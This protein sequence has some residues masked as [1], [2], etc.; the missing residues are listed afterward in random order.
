MNLQS[1]CVR[2]FQFLFLKILVLLLFL[3]RLEMLPK[4]LAAKIPYALE[5][6]DNITATNFSDANTVSAGCLLANCKTRKRIFRTNDPLSTV[7]D[8]PALSAFSHIP[9][10]HT[11][12]HT[13]SQETTTRSPISSFSPSLSFLQT[14]RN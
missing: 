10:T 11:I 3:P 12:L 4:F 1:S 7:L 13:S 14:R 8:S 2:Y 5:T 9:I 6:D